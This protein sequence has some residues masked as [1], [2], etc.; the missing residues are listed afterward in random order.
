MKI[1]AF[2]KLP[3]ANHKALNTF[4]YS[5]KIVYTPLLRNGAYT[6]DKRH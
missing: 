5:D 2:Y 3:A 6:N 4:F 1:I